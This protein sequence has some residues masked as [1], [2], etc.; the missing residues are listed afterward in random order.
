M[1][2]ALGRKRTSW[3]DLLGVLAEPELLPSLLAFDPDSVTPR[4]LRKLRLYVHS[5]CL[6][7]ENVGRV[8]KACKCIALWVHS[9]YQYCRATLPSCAG[10]R[11]DVGGDDGGRGSGAAAEAAAALG[12]VDEDAEYD[13]GA[14]AVALPSFLPSKN[15]LTELRSLKAPPA[16]VDS[17]MAAVLVLL[18]HDEGATWADAKRAIGGAD[19]FSRLSSFDPAS[20]EGQLRM[21]RARPLLDAAPSV[22]ALRSKANAAAGMLDWARA[23]VSNMV[24]N[25][26][27][28]EVGTLGTAEPPGAQALPCATADA[29]TT[30]GRAALPAWLSTVR[31]A[32]GTAAKAERL[33]AVLGE[34]SEAA[35]ARPQLT[36]RWA[37]LRERC[38][39]A[40]E[41]TAADAIA[42]VHAAEQWRWAAEGGVNTTP[43]EAGSGIDALGLR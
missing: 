20:A 21:A 14:A 27:S 43:F 12:T 5:P 26:V 36:S 23:M 13:G 2:I 22:G 4:T 39:T 8:S 9:V 42:R 19:F 15:D 16:G 7:P 6:A 32:E 33:R 31:S 10:L 30:T 17:A 11:G 28:S 37:A 29:T 35:A 38:N 3:A 1:A 18:G 34:L 40:E 25:M 24:S 41:L